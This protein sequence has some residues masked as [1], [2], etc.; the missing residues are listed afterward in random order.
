MPPLVRRLDG[1]PLI[2]H[3]AVAGASGVRDGGIVF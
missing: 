2:I 1:H 3:P